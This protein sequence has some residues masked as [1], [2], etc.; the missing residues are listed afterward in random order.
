MNTLLPGFLLLLNLLIGYTSDKTFIVHENLIAIKSALL[1]GTMPSSE[2]IKSLDPETGDENFSRMASSI[3]SFSKMISEGAGK[4][5]L[6]SVLNIY[7]DE[8]YRIYG[9]EIFNQVIDKKETRIILFITTLSCECTIKMCR[10]YE[11]AVY[12]ILPEKSGNLAI[13]DA[14]SD[15]TLTDLYKISFVPV[16]I[17]LDPE[18][19]EI[20]RF[21][22]EE[23]ISEKLIQLN[24]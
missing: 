19:K 5:T 21:T 14:Y 15:D 13:I 20:A 7:S 11:A 6:L 4:D 16:L 17:I 18:N 9:R 10:D 12:K 1:N 22:M 3:S 2:M 8:F 23:N 24:L